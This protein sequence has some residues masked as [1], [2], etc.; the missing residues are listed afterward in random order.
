MDNNNFIGELTSEWT[1]I[2][3]KLADLTLLFCKEDRYMAGQRDE[4]RLCKLL[5]EDPNG[6]L[7]CERDCSAPLTEAH[8][9]KEPVYFKCYAH[10]NNVAIPVSQNMGNGDTRYILGG[11]ILTSY[12]DLVAYRK[13]ADTLGIDDDSISDVVKGISTKNIAVFKSSAD[14]LKKVVNQ[15]LQSSSRQARMEHDIA[16]INTIIRIATSPGI[17]MDEK[18]FYETVLNTIG[19]LFNVKTAMLM[20]REDDSDYFSTEAVF[21]YDMEFLT[22]FRVNESNHMVNEVVIRK[23]VMSSSEVF[24]MPE[25]G[26]P[27]TF[28][29]IKIFPVIIGNRVDGLIII[30]NTRI[31]A[32]DEE[33][34]K[35]F[36]QCISTVLGKHILASARSDV[37]NRVLA[38]LQ[39]LYAIASCTDSSDL[40]TNIVEKSA[41]VVGA[42]QGS[43][44]LL[45]EETHQIEVRSTKGLNFAILSHIRIRPGEG[46]A[47][48][49]LQTGVPMAISNIEED[50][51]VSRPNR[52]RY[53][54]KSFISLPLMIRNKGIGVLNLADKRDGT[55]FSEND[56]KLLEAI[57]LYSAAAVERR[58]YYQSSIDLRKISITDSL[59]GLL[60]RRYFEER[61]SEEFERS[62]RHKQPFSLIILDI[63]NFKSLNDSYGHLFGDEI[64]KTTTSVIRRCVRI[65]DIAA[66][67]GGEEFAI[68]LPTTDKSGTSIIAE[69]I[70]AEVEST[71]THVRDTGATINITVSLGIASFPEDASVAEELVNNADRALYRAKSQGK[72]KVV[73]FGSV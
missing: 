63:D 46:I 56:I 52:L 37:G 73:I 51:R 21:G 26:F 18:A 28:T 17:L 16:R 57:A 33:L 45:N 35:M 59:T 14:A 3:A 7:Y 61:L 15:M 6:K 39:A 70:R 72:N 25:A 23:D 34:L 8:K 40:F 54:T 71:I 2:L 5:Q 1:G 53:K 49:V 13:V 32:Q 29:S 12:D 48:R 69:R 22:G 64:L 4:S 65:I 50:K 66:R 42:E 44:M 20:I 60:N 19:V 41:E 47:G 43:L 36:C 58:F 30:F 68:I 38:S 11:R 9:R 31:T 62:R 55:G 27:D 24:E 67:Y 10:L